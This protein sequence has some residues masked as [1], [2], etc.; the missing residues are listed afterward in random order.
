LRL[1]T[2]QFRAPSVTSV[3][4]LFDYDTHL[5]HHQSTFYRRRGQRVMFSSASA[6]VGIGR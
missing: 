5:A 4:I 3:L 6:A 1:A 2:L